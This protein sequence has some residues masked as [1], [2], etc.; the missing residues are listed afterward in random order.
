MAWGWDH[1]AGVWLVYSV[2]H[3]RTLVAALPPGPEAD[4]LIGGVVAVSSHV[5]RYEPPAEPE[6]GP[7]PRLG[8][9]C[10]PA[11]AHL[12]GVRS[13]ALVP[14]QLFRDLRARGA[15]LLYE[16]DRGW[17]TERT[18]DRSGGGGS[19]SPGACAG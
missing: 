6:R 10:A 15:E 13:R 8:M 9:W 17:I 11:V 2:Y 18:A 16:A 19:E 1:E 7:M 14:V 3:A 4:A 12:L 5:L